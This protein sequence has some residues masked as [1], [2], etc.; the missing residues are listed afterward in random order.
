MVTTDC[1]LRFLL[2]QFCCIFCIFYYQSKYC[3]TGFLQ[4]ARLKSIYFEILVQL[5]A[6]DSFVIINNVSYALAKVGLMLH[7]L[8]DDKILD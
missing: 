7:S 3:A 6:S 2:G 4:M 1:N 8:P 5:F